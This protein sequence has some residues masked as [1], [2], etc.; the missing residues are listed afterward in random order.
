[1]L[2]VIAIIALLVG[3]LVPAV[4][5]SLNKAGRVQCLDHLRG[6]HQLS[7]VYSTEHDGYTLPQRDENE[8]WFTLLKKFMPTNHRGDPITKPF[9]CPK[10]T[11]SWHF[12]YGM[13]GRPNVA[14]GDNTLNRIRSGESGR[15]LS[16]DEI[17][18]P[19][20]TPMFIDFNEWTFQSILVGSR[21]PTNR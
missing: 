18:S 1:M 12:G 2:V 13:N 5:R 21:F 3:L 17:R 15:N 9:S 6:L 10:K 14:Y 4:S 19:S 20:R 7:M 8:Q 11:N 16:F